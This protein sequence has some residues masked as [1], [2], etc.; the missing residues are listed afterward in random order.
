MRSW[1]AIL[2][3]ISIFAQSLAANA[4][5]TSYYIA[6]NGDDNNSGSKDA[7]LATLT[8]ARDILRQHQLQNKIPPEGGAR[9]LFAPGDYLISQTIDFGWDDNGRVD[10]RIVIASENPEQPA[11]LIGGVVITNFTQLSEQNA[12]SQIAEAVRGKIYTSDLS[13]LGIGELGSLSRRGFALTAKAS[14]N[15]LFYDGKP[16]TLAQY[17]NKGEFSKIADIP[18]ATSGDGHG[19]Q[20]GEL[21]NGFIYEGDRPASWAKPAAE[22]PIWAHGYWAYDWANSYERVT[23]IDTSKKVIYTESVHYG[24]RKDQRVSYVNI[25]EELDQPGEYYI[26][27]KTKTLYFYPPHD[28][29]PNKETMISTLNE[30]IIRAND[31]GFIAFQNLRFEATCA[32]AFDIQKSTSILLSNCDFRNIGTTAVTIDGGRGCLV[33]R[34]NFE[35]TGDGGVYVIGGNRKTL[36]PGGHIVQDCTLHDIGRW[37]KCYVPAISISGVGI[38]ARHNLIYNHPHAGILWGGNEHTIEFNEIHDV[39]LETG[40]VGAIYAGRDYTMRGNKIQYNY[41]HDVNGPAGMGSMGIYNDDNLSGTYMYGNI[42]RNVQR[43]AFM[44]GGRDFVV[45]NNIFIDCKPAIAID[46]R[47]LD[48]SPVWY[49]QVYQTLKPSFEAAPRELYQK[50][51]PE[52]YTIEKYLATTNGVPPENILIKNN[53]SLGGEWKSVGWHATDDMISWE[54][55]IIDQ[56]PGFAD[57]KNGDYTIKAD[58]E[59]LKNGFVPLP[60]DK[61]G[62]RKENK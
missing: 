15:E 34:C 41:I 17:P 61:M 31:V 52:M 51:Y 10:R 1:Y 27:R 38:R 36:K 53:I 50:R 28:G 2:G 44:G 47:G 29:A 60:F 32:K 42:F 11:R 6:P 8:R 54:N 18:G 3:A 26:D 9:I 21:K 19:G 40:D 59:A 49:N 25:L 37:S 24:F 57:V 43:A 7:P 55:N 4:E 39:A 5:T 13:Q 35:N 30:P 20:L 12:P 16:M 56:D 58:S 14:H 23:D 48:K 22:N 45:Q 46:G 33:S 62:P